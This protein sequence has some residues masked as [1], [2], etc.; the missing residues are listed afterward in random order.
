M[1]AASDYIPKV[2]TAVPAASRGESPRQAD[3]HVAIM[4]HRENCSV[5][6]VK[7]NHSSRGKLYNMETWIDTKKKKTAETAST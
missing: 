1:A 7:R 2:T 6:H 4:L 3:A 5:R